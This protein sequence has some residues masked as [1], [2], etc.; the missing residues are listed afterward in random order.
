[1]YSVPPPP[2]HGP[3]MY[4]VYLPTPTP[5]PCSTCADH[6][7]NLNRKRSNELAPYKMP[8]PGRKNKNYITIHCMN[9]R[10]FIYRS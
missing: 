1:M 8:C 2:S 5:S 3:L 9:L 7:R 6:L 10:S 4:S